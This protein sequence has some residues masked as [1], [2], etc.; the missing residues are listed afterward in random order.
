MKKQIGKAVVSIA[1]LLSVS[2]CGCGNNPYKGMVS[3]PDGA[4]GE[5]LVELYEDL[6]VSNF[7]SEGFSD[8]GEYVDYDST[9][10][11]ALRGIDVSEHQQ[12]I[13]WNSVK[14]EEIDFAIIRAGYSGY[15][16]GESHVD[17]YFEK[18]IEGALNAG[19]NVGV[20]FFSQAINESE[21]REEAEFLLDIIK[22][23]KI[24]MPVFFDWEPMYEESSRT[25]DIDRTTLTDCCL[26]FCKTI[27]DAGYKAGVYFY[28]SLGYHHYELDRLK[29]LTFWA[30]APGDYP[31]F[32]YEH[33]FWQYTSTAKINGIEGNV[34][35]DLLFVPKDSSDKQ[36]N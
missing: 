6:P 16:N 10:Y 12:E 18:N 29:G 4:G 9:E 31:D 1:V 17:K 32:Y 26:E 7:T 15:S 25:S 2:L 36:L 21:A 27:E 23:Y 33:N 22:E 24:T 5:M 8:N 34:D 28:R 35:L 20:Y 3:V 19:Q 13:D 11:T 14:A 30:G